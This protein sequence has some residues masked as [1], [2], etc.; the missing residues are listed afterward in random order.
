MLARLLKPLSLPLP[1]TLVS[2]PGLSHGPKRRPKPV[3]MSRLFPQPKP[4]LYIHAKALLECL[5]KHSPDVISTYVPVADL[6]RVYLDDVCVQQGWKPRKWAGIG[7]QLGRLTRDKKPL[8]RDG[9]RHTA[10]LIPAP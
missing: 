3:R 5:Q 6:I 9:Q 7:R 10:Y 4:E 2:I 8:R 1:P